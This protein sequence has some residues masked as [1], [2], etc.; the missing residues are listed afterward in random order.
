M[1][2]VVLTA[3]NEPP[4]LVERPTPT[5]GRGEVLVRVKACGVCGTD[6]RVQQGKSKFARFPRVVGHEAVGEIA[7]LGEGVIGLAVGQ[8]VGVPIC[9]STCGHCR[10]CVRGDQMLCA[11]LEITGITRDGGF[12]QFMLARAGYVVPLP[13]G[14]E[15]AEAAPLLCAGVTVFNGLRLSGFRPGDRVA[16]IGLGG[17]GQLAVLFARAMGGR[18]LVVSHSPGKEAAARE[19]GAEAFVD[20]GKE[21]VTARLSAW[22]GGPQVSLNTSPDNGIVGRALA[23][24]APDSTFV[25]LGIGP[26]ELVIRPHELVHFRRRVMGVPAGSPKD[27]ADALELAAAQKIRPRV[28]PFPLAQAGAVLEK[29]RAGTLDG[30]AVLTMDGE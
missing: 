4:V 20:S 18:V 28:T 27:V 12:Q 30:R 8:A 5:P 13:S 11:Q 24:M 10:M 29:M 25:Q 17:L 16:V 7:A 9:W 3:P 23:G 26:G 19:L 15:P 14:L 6:L 1:K 2:A 22:G 21:D